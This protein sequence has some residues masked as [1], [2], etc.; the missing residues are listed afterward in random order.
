MT[1]GESGSGKV[2]PEEIVSL[3]LGECADDDKRFDKAS[4]LDIHKIDFFIEHQGRY[5]SP[6]DIFQGK[7]F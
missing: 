3:L 7:N 6:M 5:F 4:S 2:R 1:I